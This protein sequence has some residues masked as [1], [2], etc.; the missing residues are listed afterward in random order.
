MMNMKRRFRTTTNIGDF[1]QALP[2]LVQRLYT[3][4]NRTLL[5]QPILGS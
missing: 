2:G 3:F 5:I 1:K 4:Y